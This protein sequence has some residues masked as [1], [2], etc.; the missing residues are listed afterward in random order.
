[1]YKL[2]LFFHLMSDAVSVITN[3]FN[4]VFGPNN[5]RG[6]CWFH[7]KKCVDHRLRKVKNQAKRSKL[8]AII[9][10]LQICQSKAN[11]ESKAT[12]LKV[13]NTRKVIV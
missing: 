2:V 10:S 6:F 7:L 1:M 9:I 13:T 12:G 4:M 8:I 3:G 5:V 11:Y